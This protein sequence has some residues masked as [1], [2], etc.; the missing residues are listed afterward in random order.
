MNQTKSFTPVLGL[1]TGIVFATGVT[2]RGGD[3]AEASRNLHIPDSIPTPLYIST[4]VNGS[5]VVLAG[6]D[7]DGDNI[8]FRGTLDST[9]T[10][11]SLNYVLNGS[12]GRRC[13]TDNGSGTLGKR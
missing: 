10:L 9:G 4:V 12:A 11:L 8:T 1:S 6:S 3:K 2:G 5:A 7:A 13:E